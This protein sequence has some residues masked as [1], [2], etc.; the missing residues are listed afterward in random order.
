MASTT[1]DAKFRDETSVKFTREYKAWILNDKTGK[2]D[3]EHT[4]TTGQTGTVLSSMPSSGRYTGYV[5]RRYTVMLHGL[6]S[7]ITLVAVEE[8]LLDHAQ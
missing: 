2:N 8:E 5:G 6:S 4:V 7:H 1:T 3:T